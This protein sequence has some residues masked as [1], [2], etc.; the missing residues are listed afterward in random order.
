M[1][2]PPSS[3]LLTIGWCFFMWTKQDL[4]SLIKTNLTEYRFFVVSNRQP[5][6]HIR[7]KGKIEA[8]RGVGGV[9]TALDPVMQTCE[10]TWVAF[11]N[12]EADRLATD[13]D[14]KIKVPAE[15][16][17]YTLKRV[18]LTKEEEQ[19]Y[20]YG[21]SNSAIWPLCHMTFKRPIFNTEDWEYYKQVN[22][23][24]AQA[25]IDEAGD[26][27]SFIWVQDFHFCLLPK[28]LKELRPNQF[29]IAHFWHI[30][31][32]AHEIFQICPQKKEILE[33]L[34][35]ND[36]LGFHI[37]YHCMNF[38][39]VIDREIE[40]KIDRERMSVIKANHETLVR[41]YPISID[42]ESIKENADSKEVKDVVHGLK[43]E[44][45]LSGLKVMV[46][47]DRIDYTKGLPEKLL[48]VD[49]LLENHPELIGKVVLLQI[50]V[51]SRIHL[52]QYKDLNEEINDLIED[53]NWK[54][55][56]DGWKP[57][58]FIR[59][60]F[61]LSQLTALYRL[62]DVGIVSSLHDGMNLVAKEYIASCTDTKG[63][64][65]L[66]QFTGAAR[67]LLDAI[68]INPYDGMQF[69][70]GLYQAL[71]MHEEERSK[72]MGKMGEQ[73]KANNIYRWAGKIISELLKF[74]FKE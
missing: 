35:A 32:P 28:Y 38:M 41:P 54:Y 52:K 17:S 34:L 48:A 70:E 7:K 5:Y 61:S 59:Q 37:R 15:N 65:V 40:C 33:G 2:G 11:G 68:L 24:F 60:Q 63:M 4:Q 18:W 42:F 64:L 14:G 22:L 19:G 67:E 69:S 25:I 47:L 3:G 43:E 8:H 27:K 39:D 72:R 31:W 56:K 45:K 9:V 53:I 51:L 6:D 55:A 26:R 21:F 36:L 13:S 12:G 20:Y 62:S 30:P 29:I 58:V 66:S 57:I 16:P 1:V 50:G 73:I 46:G 74:E 10:G 71:M 49:H 44:H 23:K